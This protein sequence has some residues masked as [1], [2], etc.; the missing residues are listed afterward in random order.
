[1]A[2]VK[3]SPMTE[4]EILKNHLSKAGKKGNAA[5]RKKLTPEEI[6]KNA[7]KGGKARWKK[8]SK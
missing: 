5:M 2:S 4:E 8:S 1:M 3:R 6:K 7:R